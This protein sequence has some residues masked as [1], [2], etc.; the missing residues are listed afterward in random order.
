M[1]KK[2]FRGNLVRQIARCCV[3]L[4]YISETDAPITVFTGDAVHE[5]DPRSMCAS[6]HLPEGLQVTEADFE[7]FFSRLTTIE[8]WHGDLQREQI[9][10]FL[11]LKQL[12][13]ENLRD[14]KVFKVGE[15][16]KNVYAVGLD[17]DNYVIGVSTCAVET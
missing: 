13:E 6:A 8:P 7:K 3:G 5:L 1:K 12:L 11:E 4:V 2:K 10:K 14:L 9:K 15:I 17:D 16:R